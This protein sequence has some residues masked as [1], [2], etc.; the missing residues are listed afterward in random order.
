MRKG[1]HR[2]RVWSIVKTWPLR[3]SSAG[4][5]VLLLSLMGSLA[6]VSG[7]GLL[8]LAGTGVLLVSCPQHFSVG[9]PGRGILGRK[10]AA[11]VVEA[12]GLLSA[13]GRALPAA[14]L[15]ALG[16]CSDMRRWGV[17]PDSGPQ[18][19]GLPLCRL[20]SSSPQISPSPAGAFLSYALRICSG[21]GISPIA[22][23]REKS[24]PAAACVRSD[25][26]L[27]PLHTHL[28]PDP[29]IWRWGVESRTLGMHS[30]CSPCAT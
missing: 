24:H 15:A 7:C 6:R 12:G 20:L 25:Q 16:A 19:K 10:Q 23:P 4:G 3:S 22:Q 29:F 8:G 5:G 17:F 1:P 21:G 30:T 2:T 9:K 26:P 11:C 27:P 28:L 13:W 18:A 14:L